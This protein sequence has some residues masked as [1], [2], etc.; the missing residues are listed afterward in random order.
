MANNQHVEILKNG[1][2]N[3]HAWRRANPNIR[4]DLSGADLSNW[5]FRA[6][7]LRGTCLVDTDLSHA[8]L[9][10]ALFTGA[11]CSSGS[12]EC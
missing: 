12:R 3:W 2:E 6:V 8:V 7:D 5:D 9:S 4:P 11:I 10:N 1:V